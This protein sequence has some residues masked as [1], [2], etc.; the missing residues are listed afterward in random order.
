MYIDVLESYVVFRDHHDLNSKPHALVERFQTSGL[1]YMHAP[2]VLQHSLVAMTNTEK[3]PMLDMVKYLRM[4]MPP[5]EL[6]YHVWENQGGDSL[7]FLTHI[8]NSPPKF[9]SVSN[10]GLTTTDFASLLSII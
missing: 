8:L 2:V 6:H 5:K 4:Y 3:I 1:C 9:I 7:D 10:L